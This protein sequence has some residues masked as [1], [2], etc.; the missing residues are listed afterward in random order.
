MFSSVSSKILTSNLEAINAAC[1]SSLGIVRE[2]SF[3]GAKQDFTVMNETLIS[4]L[5]IIL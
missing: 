2:F 1:G 5:E 3:S 4:K